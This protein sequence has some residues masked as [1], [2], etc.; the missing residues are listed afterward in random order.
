MRRFLV[1]LLPSIFAF[2]LPFSVYAIEF[3]VGNPQISGQQITVDVSLSGV[4]SSNCP[5]AKCYL[6]GVLRSVESSY[7]FGETQN[8]KGVWIEYVSKPEKE[9]IT[10]NFPAIDIVD[11]SWS[12]QLKI[13]YKADDPNYKGP[14]THDLKV[15]RFTGGSS[16]Y[17]GEAAATVNLITALPQTPTPTPQPTAAPTP[18]PAPTKSPTPTPT[19]TPTLTSTPTPTSQPTPT[20]TPE[21]TPMVLGESVETK[22]SSPSSFTQNN[23][24]R[25]MVISFLLVATGCA[26]LAGFYTWKIAREKYASDILDK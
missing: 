20:E 15:R 23:S 16:S 9:F 24:W 26:I 22:T 21:A 1:F 13:Q 3:T 19:K 25:P 18:T 7:Y 11:A 6:Q 17:A 10:E 8:N 5:S 4:S 12:G 14:G 2:S